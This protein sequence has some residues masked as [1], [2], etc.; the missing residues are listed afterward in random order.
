MTSFARV[1]ETDPVVLKV[2]ELV[3]KRVAP[4]MKELFGPLA[5]LNAKE[6]E[7]QMAYDA[8]GRE[9]LFGMLDNDGELLRAL[10][11][12]GLV[13]TFTTSADLVRAMVKM[14]EVDELALE[15]ALNLMP[16]HGF[17]FVARKGQSV[18]ALV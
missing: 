13:N 7:W 2:W 18:V 5:T 16:R 8:L 12:I 3:E 17:P 11:G 15:K 9:G 4:A 14:L 1:L 10:A 6:P